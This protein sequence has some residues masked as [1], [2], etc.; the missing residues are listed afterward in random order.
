M[1]LQTAISSKPRIRLAATTVNKER[2]ALFLLFQWWLL[3][4]FT[5]EINVRDFIIL[6][7]V[8]FEKYVPRHDTYEV[9][10]N[11]GFTFGAGCAAGSRKS[12]SIRSYARQGAPGYRLHRA[13]RGLEPALVGR[14]QLTNTFLN[15][16]LGLCLFLQIIRLDLHTNLQPGQPCNGH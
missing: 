15:H 7:N 9:G 1:A 8:I 12:I 3:Q 5:K 16:N 6:E 2:L 4:L 13:L 10:R 14:F 11:A